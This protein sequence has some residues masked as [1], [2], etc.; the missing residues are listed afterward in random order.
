[1]LLYLGTNPQL[2]FRVPGQGSRNQIRTLHR[3]HHVEVAQ[4]DEFAAYAAEQCR[5]IDA[6]VETPAQA[7]VYSDE[8]TFP[9]PK[10]CW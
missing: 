8:P 7:V 3:H 5:G 9:Q 4:K 10:Y 2:L 6:V 1:M